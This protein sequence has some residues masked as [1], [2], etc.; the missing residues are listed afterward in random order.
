M[1]A[2]VIHLPYPAKLSKDGNSY[3]RLDGTSQTEGHSAW[4]SE[5]E[6]VGSTNLV[7]NFERTNLASAEFLADKF[8]GV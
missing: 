4:F 3:Q 8:V 6:G 5:T 7:G 1:L 2:C